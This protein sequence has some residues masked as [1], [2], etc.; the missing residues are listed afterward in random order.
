MPPP[1][2][3]GGSHP[4]PDSP[5]ETSPGSGVLGRTRQLYLEK[6]ARTEAYH[7][8]PTGC[9]PHST[10]PRHRYPRGAGGGCRCWWPVPPRDTDARALG[11]GWGQTGHPH[12][13]KA[14]QGT[15][16]WAW[17]ST[18]D[19]DSPQ[20]PLPGGDLHGGKPRR[21]RVPW[22]M[23]SPDRRTAS[24]APCLQFL[25]RSGSR[26]AALCPAPRPAGVGNPESLPIPGR[27]PQGCNLRR[28]VIIESA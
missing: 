28:G 18:E 12:V 22:G 8:E 20:A 3:W 11:L 16:G 7:P 10:G 19:R 25:Q 2:S 27:A 4:L 23:C 1:C 5:W 17:V 26:P 21:A 24:R 6:E 13:A 9:W 15:W 14:G